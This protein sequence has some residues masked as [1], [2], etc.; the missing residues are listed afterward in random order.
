MVCR[1][2]VGCDGYGIGLGG[3]PRDGLELNLDLKVNLH[4]R[5][6]EIGRIIG[7]F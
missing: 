6:L 1:T 5:F 2:L 7:L 4:V 3:W